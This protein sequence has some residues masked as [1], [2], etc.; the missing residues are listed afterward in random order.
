M[1]KLLQ[2][3]YFYCVKTL[4][5]TS[6]EQITQG[7]GRSEDDESGEQRDDQRGTDLTLVMMKDEQ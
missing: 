6:L 3:R 7:L 4:N 2:S 5:M 1:Q